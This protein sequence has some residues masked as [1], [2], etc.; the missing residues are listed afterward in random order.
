VYHLRGCVKYP[1]TEGVELRGCSRVPGEPN[2]WRC[3]AAIPA[4]ATGEYKVAV[5]RDHKGEL[6]WVPGRGLITPGLV[7][8]T[9]GPLHL[10]C[11]RE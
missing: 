4:D 1:V 11:V 2:N 10:N 3:V 9:I 6:L 8:W 7:T 5:K